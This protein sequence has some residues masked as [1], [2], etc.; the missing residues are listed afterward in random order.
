MELASEKWGGHPHY[1]GVVHHLGDDEHGMW[2][3]GPAGRT[4]Y[5]GEV[6]VFVTELATVT[7]IP[8]GAWWTPTWWVG[9]TEIE[10]YVNINTPAARQGDRI[11]S[12][13][14]D[15]DVIRRTDGTVEIIDRDEFEVHQ[16]RYGYPPELIA[17]TERAAA[18]AYDRVVQNVP[19]FDGVAAADW[20]RQ[21]KPPRAQR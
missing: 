6:A 3:W 9:H 2:V 4:I 19:P 10:L 17:G 21:S 14:V 12:V 1:R 18:E 7:V 8:P 15:L 20:L 13:D 11:V 16:V 5:R